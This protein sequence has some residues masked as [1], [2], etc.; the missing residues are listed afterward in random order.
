MYPFRDDNVYLRN[1]WYVAA[2]A[3]EIDAGPLER[4]IM[5][6][7]VALFRMED[8]RPAAMHGVCPHRYYPLAQGRVVGGSLQC[9]YHGFRFDGETGSCVAVPSQ[10]A[11]PKGFRQRVYPVAE[12]AGWIWIWPGE[13]D[14]ADPALLP[15]LDAMGTAEGWLV[16][17]GQCLHGEGRA[18]LLVENLLDLT[19]IDF[20]HAT[21]LQAEGVLDFP[22]KLREVDGRILATRMSR[23]PWLHGFYDL[24]YGTENHF[25]GMHDTIGDTW[26]WSPAYLRTGLAID[27]IDGRESVDRRV[28]GNFYFQHF[29]TPETAHSCHY[30]AGM[31]RDYRQDDAH[32]SAVMMAKDTDVRQQDID[33][34][35][36]VEAQ[37]ARPWTLSPELLVKSDAPA[38]Q[39]RRTIQ[40]D[41]DKEAA[42]VAVAQ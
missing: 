28:F 13:P 31:S 36:L 37:L 3:A 22:V 5:D 21:T 32:L 12:H 17:V 38:I 7:P 39:V 14:L 18:Q 16:Q 35:K 25:D 2:T 20:L 19:H 4:T 40:K 26:Y 15:P 30:F 34:I 8:G 9:N 10:A 42:V 23:A 1:C 33:A 11:A 41:L 24:I 29:I 27:R 6:N